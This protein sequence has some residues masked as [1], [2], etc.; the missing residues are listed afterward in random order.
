MSPPILIDRVSIYTLLVRI[1]TLTRIISLNMPI[2][3][4]KKIDK[5]RGDVPREGRGIE[6][7]AGKSSEAA[8]QQKLVGDQ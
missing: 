1:H 4:R 3:L 7:S 6:S 5:D 8:N 2:E